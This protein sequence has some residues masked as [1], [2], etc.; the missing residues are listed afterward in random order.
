KGASL[1]ADTSTTPV[2]ILREQVTSKGGTTEQGLLSLENLKVKQAIIQAAQAAEKRAKIL[3]D[4]L[5][6]E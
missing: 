4:Q 3:G 6:N 1:L 5:G 2:N